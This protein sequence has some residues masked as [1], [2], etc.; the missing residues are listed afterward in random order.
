M[1]LE[2]NHH[3]FDDQRDDGAEIGDRDHAAIGSTPH[4]EAN[5]RWLGDN[6]ADRSSPPSQRVRSFGGVALAGG[7]AFASIFAMNSLKAGATDQRGI[8]GPGFAQNGAPP[9]FGPG[10]AGVA[11]TPPTR[12]LPT[13]PAGG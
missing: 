3:P 9:G 11:P 4:F 13:N 12:G 5:E 8:G 2:N 10:P 6:D 1:T 7:L